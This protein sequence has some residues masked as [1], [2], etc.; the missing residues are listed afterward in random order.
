M[1]KKSFKKPRYPY[2]RTQKTARLARFRKEEAE[3]QKQ[4]SVARDVK[5]LNTI[6]ENGNEGNNNNYK[7]NNEIPTPANIVAPVANQ[8]N[9]NNNNTVNQ[10]LDP[11]YN[12]NLPTFGRSKRYPPSRKVKQAKKNLLRTRKQKQRLQTLERRR[13]REGKESERSRNNANMNEIS[14]KNM[15]SNTTNF[16]K[17]TVHTVVSDTVA[18]WSLPV[19]I[20]ETF[21]NLEKT[22]RGER[23]FD[24][25]LVE[26]LY[27]TDTPGESYYVFALI[28]FPIKGPLEFYVF[29]ADPSE[30]FSKHNI[31]LDKEGIDQISWAQKIDQ[32]FPTFESVVRFLENL[33][34]VKETLRHKLNTYNYWYNLQERMEENALIEVQKKEEQQA[35]ELFDKA[36]PNSF[37]VRLDRRPRLLKVSDLPG[38]FRSYFYYHNSLEIL[39]KGTTEENSYYYYFKREDD[40]VRDNIYDYDFYASTHVETFWEVKKVNPVN[41]FR[42]KFTTYYYN[43]WYNEENPYEGPPGTYITRFYRPSEMANFAKSL[44]GFREK[45]DKEKQAV[46]TAPAKLESLQLKGLEGTIQAFEKKTGK[47]V[48]RDVQNVIERYLMRK[49]PHSTYFQQRDNIYRIHPNLFTEG[50]VNM[51]RHLK[52]IHTDLLNKSL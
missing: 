35:K 40:V 45:V 3:R 51:P 5:L 21:T 29:K 11:L 14:F 52:K 19:D 15:H 48:P 28:H 10:R 16:V 50:E 25:N 47:T 39:Y 17:D 36:L 33:P 23:E 27:L 22:A 41:F 9:N 1:P 6:L 30:F 38:N 34:N 12:T 37:Y 8:K 49:P 42:T 46:Y 43:N 18:H 31:P 44:P 7:N 4:R 13:A 24:F 20:G 2:R 32:P 26:V